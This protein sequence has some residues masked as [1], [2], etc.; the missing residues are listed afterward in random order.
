MNEQIFNSVFWLSI[1]TMFLTSFSVLL[2][3]CLKSKCD[4]IDLCCGL[5]K[6][7]RAVEIEDIE[8]GQSTPPTP[9]NN[10]NNI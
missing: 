10:D 8:I 7:H 6:V 2:K 4:K 1:S 3:Y 5:I 9:T